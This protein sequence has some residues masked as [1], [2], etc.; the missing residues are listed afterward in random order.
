MGPA[1]PRALVGGDTG[2]PHGGTTKKARQR[3]KRV[4]KGPGDP[5]PLG[6]HRS[7]SHLPLPPGP[8]GMSRHPPAVPG[9]A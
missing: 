8:R 4:L 7:P 6:G 9:L 3:W 5:A 2:R 1:A